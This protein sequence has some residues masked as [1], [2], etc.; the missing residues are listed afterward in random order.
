MLAKNLKIY[1]KWKNIQLQLSKSEK[2]KKNE[3]KWETNTQGKREKLEQ[4]GPIPGVL[5]TLS[6]VHE[7]PSLTFKIK[8]NKKK[9]RKRKRQKR[10]TKRKG[11]QKRKE[12]QLYLF[13]NIAQAAH[14][15]VLALEWAPHLVRLVT[16]RW[17]RCTHRCGEYFATHSLAKTFCPV[18]FL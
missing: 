2:N 7:N 1:F 16:H 11:E 18:F 3:K 10:K 14:H 4:K 5:R 17:D 13:L 15:R 12:G 9:R 8:K 6:L